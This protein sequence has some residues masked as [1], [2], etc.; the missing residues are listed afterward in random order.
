MALRRPSQQLFK[1]YSFTTNFIYIKLEIVLCWLLE[2]NAKIGK[3]LKNLIFRRD[4]KLFVDDSNWSISH[5]STVEQNKPGLIDFTVLF[6]KSLTIGLNA[7]DP[8]R[9]NFDRTSFLSK[10]NPSEVE[11]A[12]AH[13]DSKFILKNKLFLP[14]F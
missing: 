7:E 4:V 12:Q 2:I 8:T 14:A 13:I 9:S 3:I 11:L 5:A 1:F 10:E 6:S